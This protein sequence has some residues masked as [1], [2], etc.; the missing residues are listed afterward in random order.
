MSNPRA[1]SVAKGIHAFAELRARLLQ[2]EIMLHHSDRR[3]EAL[4]EELRASH[5]RERHHLKI[6]EE[7]KHQNPNTANAAERAG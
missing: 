7:L 6:I 1:A 3:A 4:A 5:A 2:V